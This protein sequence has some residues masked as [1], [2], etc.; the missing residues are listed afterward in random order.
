MLVNNILNIAR[1]LR[2]HAYII[3]DVLALASASF[4]LIREKNCIL[5]IRGFKTII[6]WSF[7]D[8][9]GQLP[10]I[11]AFQY[12]RF[13][14]KT[15]SDLRAENKEFLKLQRKEKYRL[16]NWLFSNLQECRNLLRGAKGSHET[17]R[18]GDRRPS[19]FG[20]R[21]SPTENASMPAT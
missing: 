3:L 5:L 14:Y 20:G 16:K 12:Y 1:Y 15:Y 19:F 8:R 6:I 7:L 13:T 21:A 18:L 9:N 2:K 4:N 17:F 11:L 10:G